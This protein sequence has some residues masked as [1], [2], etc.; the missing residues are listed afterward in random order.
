[1]A[2]KETETLGEVHTRTH[3]KQDLT[4]ILT[5]SMGEGDREECDLISILLFFKIRKE[6]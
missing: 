2:R 1:M 5:K 4:N 3:T 6:N